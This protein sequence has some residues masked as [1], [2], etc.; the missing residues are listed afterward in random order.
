MTVK[1]EI[2]VIDLALSDGAERERLCK[3][4]A[5]VAEEWGFFQVINHGVDE[6]LMTRTLDVY[7]DFF[8]SPVEE[9]TK[10]VIS[11]DSIEGWKHPTLTQA[12]EYLQHVASQFSAEYVANSWIP[13]TP[14]YTKKWP[15]T[16]AALRPTS[17]EFVNAATRLHEK[18]CRMMAEGLG[19]ES[20]AFVKHF[21][22]PRVSLRANFYPV[23]TESNFVGGLAPHSD[24]CNTTLLIDTVDG[25]EVK[26]D[27]TWVRVK[28]LPN[29]FV[30]N[31]G[32]LVEI[33][34]NGRLKSC[35]HRG[36]PNEN[37]E[38]LSVSCFYMPNDDA[39]L[40]PLD[41]LLVDGQTAKYKA[42]R[43]ADYFESLISKGNLL[44]D[45][46]EQLRVEE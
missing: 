30:V 1:L 8:H 39:V 42:V 31:V 20:D 13:A 44:K 11:E 46:I 26:K 25:L 22:D 2:P 14:K 29:A 27:D 43:F 19:L 18:L 37:K 41:E 3:E 5:K 16:P 4:V 35:L 21:V 38:R 34:S 9:K 40:A 10:A 6:S 15:P 33:L 24:L 36:C 12:S 7:E 28:V 23:K 17:I 32:D 45:R